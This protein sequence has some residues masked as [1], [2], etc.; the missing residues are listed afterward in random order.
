M[1]SLRPTGSLTALIATIG[2]LSSLY[3]GEPVS[4]APGHNLL[5]ENRIHSHV[6]IGAI[7]DSFSFKDIEGEAFY[8]SEAKKRGPMVF[9]F[10]STRCPL[11]K[12]YTQRLKRIYEAYSPK[13]VDVVAV[14]SNSD[15]TGEGVRNFAQE[16][17]YPFRVVRD[18]QGYLATRLGATMTPQVF[19]VD[20]N[21]VLRYRGAIDD[22]RYETRVKQHYLTSALDSI[23]SGTEVRQPATQSMGCRIHLAQ[24]SANGNVTYAGHVARIIQDNCQS[25]HRPGQVG[26]FS[27]T[28]Y[29]EALTW[30]TEI[31]AYTHARVMPPWKASRGVA[32]F[33]NDAS[34]TDQEIALIAKWVD[35]GAPEGEPEDVPPSP[36]FHDSW[37]FG[38][39]DLT[40][41]ML[42]E[43][44]VG[45]E[46]EDDY[47][48][49]IIPYEHH[50]DRYVEAID[51]QPGNRN[52]VHHVLAYI[53]TSGKAR[54]LD[55]EDPGPGYTRFGDTGFEPASVIGGW[56]PGN[57]PLKT[58]P[59]SGRWL[60]K[61]CDI[62]L[63]VHYY[64]TGIEERD[65]TKLGIYFSKAREPVQVV[66][67]IAEND[68]FTIPAG[69]SGVEV[70][71]EYEVE[72]PSYLFLVTPHMHMIGETMRVT[73]H[74]PD[75]KV[76]PLI[77]IDD[78][79]FNWQLS[80]QFR[81]FQY[82]PAGTI[83]KLVATFDNSKGNPNNP[84]SPPQDIQWGEKTTD[85][86]CIAFLDMLRESEYDPSTMSRRGSHR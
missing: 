15:E 85:E 7:I 81:E 30:A 27:L 8:L 9:V 14:F 35:D 17:A 42:E 64:R 84:F 62:V 26:P 24:A 32:E 44:V 46:G 3:A 60:P 65:R 34:L 20:A 57:L 67:G 6:R 36:K 10:V 1:H 29:E 38:E 25:C 11:A 2:Y 61:K 68:D 12:R 21:A 52:T 5:S 28:N 19:V 4:I 43:Y 22:H 31:K 76:I 37:A 63:Q 73:A 51:V 79:D 59:G 83:V 86:M 18:L 54:R 48:H 45:P 72:E 56:A 49:F 40:V 23:L 58:P 47:R 55:A 69:T 77:Q 33:Q 74:R 41:E 80:Y 53:D 78:W 71:A 39:P 13:G 16:V 66:D 75:G 50:K 70:R 82:L